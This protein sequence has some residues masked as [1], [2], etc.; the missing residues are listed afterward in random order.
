M[1]M[2]EEKRKL[3]KLGKL[4]K[5]EQKK[6]GKLKKCPCQIIRLVLSANG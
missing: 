3:V 6:P 4:E 1:D 2:L 5:L